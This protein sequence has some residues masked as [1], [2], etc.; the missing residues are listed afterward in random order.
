MDD[1]GA[2]V[3]LALGHLPEDGQ[4]IAAQVAGVGDLVGD[5]SG[6]VP[7]GGDDEFGA[8]VQGAGGGLML[9]VLQTVLLRAAGGRHL[10][11]L[12]AVV[13]LPA[14]AGPILGPVIGG[15]IVGHLSWRW[16][17]FVNVPLGLLAVLLACRGMPTDSPRGG[18]RLDWAGLS[19]LSPA[20]AALIYGLIQSKEKLVASGMGAVENFS[21]GAIKTIG[22]LELLAAVGLILPAAFDIAPVLVPLAAV[23]LVSLMVGAMFVHLRRH[24]AQGIVVTLT[25]FALAAFVAWGRFGPESFTG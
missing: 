14:L 25:L 8:V 2:D 21:P 16:I 4:H 5:G 20:L 17:F 13:T 10:G 19:L 18:E 15:L 23:G 12:M 24:E 22:T 11:R 6:V 9:P 3:A 1:V 7:Q